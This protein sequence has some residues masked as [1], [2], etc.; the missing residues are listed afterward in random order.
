MEHTNYDQGNKII[1]NTEDLKSNLC[2]YNEDYVLVRDKT[3]I[4]GH[5]ATQVAL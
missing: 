4:I 5:Q 2:D 3:S 1:Y